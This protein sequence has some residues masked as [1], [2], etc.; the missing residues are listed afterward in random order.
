[1][2]CLRFLVQGSIITASHMSIMPKNTT[3]RRCPL[4]SGS[5]SRIMASPVCSQY[6]AAH[7]K[8]LL[9]LAAVP[10]LRPRSRV[11]A[12]PAH[13]DRSIPGLS[14]H[15]AYLDLSSVRSSSVLTPAHSRASAAFRGCGERGAVL[16]AFGGLFGGVKHGGG[17]RLVVRLMTVVGGASGELSISE[18]KAQLARR[19]RTGVLGGS[20]D[21]GRSV[22]R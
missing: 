9:S 5:R 19:G 14:G 3:S 4:G 12:A 18:A 21:S 16:L 8:P 6:F 13:M 17:W 7:L 11:A 20:G 22:F 15:R 1:M 2:P 10:F